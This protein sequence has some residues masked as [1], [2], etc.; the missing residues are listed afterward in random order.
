M[1]EAA[2]VWSR[3]GTRAPSTI[4]TVFGLYRWQ[5]GARA[6]YG[7][8]RSMLRCTAAVHRGGVDPEPWRQLPHRQVSPVLGGDQQPIGQR[9]RPLP[10]LDLVGDQLPVPALHLGDQLPKRPQRQP[11]EHLDQLRTRHGE[12]RRHDR[13]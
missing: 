8:S 7:P 13:R 11:G 5:A 6:S 1:L 3:V 10:T 12:Y 2:T 9:Q 4:S